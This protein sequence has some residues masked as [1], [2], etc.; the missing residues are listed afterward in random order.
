MATKPKKSASI[1]THQ[2]IKEQTDTFLKAGGK[3]QE[4]ARGITGQQKLA[5]PRQIVLG[6]PSTKSAS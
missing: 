4:V 5:G 6:N 3:I 1:E 2:S